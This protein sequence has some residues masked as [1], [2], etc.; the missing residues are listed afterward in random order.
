MFC[1]LRSFG[2][3][4]SVTFTGT[5]AATHIDSVT[6]TNQR[7]NQCITLPGNE[8][9]VLTL[10]TG[11]PMVSEFTNQGM[12]FPNPFPGKATF[13]T[14]IQKPQTVYLNV[15]NLVGQVVAQIQA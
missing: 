10:N 15:Q 11:I 12:V 3:N 8:T 2:Q 14:V 5:G 7:T 1:C 13:T 9:L 6:A 4:I